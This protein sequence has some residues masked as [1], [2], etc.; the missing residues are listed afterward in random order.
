MKN[1][2]HHLL[3]VASPKRIF[4][5][6]QYQKLAKKAIE[7]ILKKSKLPI[8]CGGAGLFIDSI[9]YGAKFPEVPPQPN[10]RKK[11]DKK[12]T[13]ELFK[14][15]QELDFRRVKNIDKNN[16]HR[17]IRALEIVLTTKLPVPPFN[18]VAAN[19][20]A[21]LIGIKKSPEELKI[22]IAKRLKKR[23]KQGMIEE[24][25]KLREQGLS[26]KRLDD[27]GL[28]YR[29]VSRHLRGLITK[30]EMVE[31]IMK[32]S[33]QYAK[34]QMT[35]FK[36]DKNIIWTDNPQEAAAISQDWLAL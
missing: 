20:D 16:R 17:L 11:L 21:L 2:P 1:I 35:W 4:T 12:T 32:K 6:S 8:I 34:R 24:L 7:K 23:L 5:V 33:R 3:D 13:E 27:L 25:K 10:L 30:K 15:L 9:I 26:W 28:E 36:R 31:S 22:L 19:Y 29:Y 14:Q 18:K